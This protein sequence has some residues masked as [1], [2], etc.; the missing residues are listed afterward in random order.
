MR[1]LL[2][3]KPFLPSGVAAVAQ[4]AT[5][6]TAARVVV[7]VRFPLLIETVTFAVED[8][9]VFPDASWIVATG[10]VVKFARFTKPATPVVTTTL[11]AA[12]ALTAIVCAASVMPNIE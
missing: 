10:C 7:P 9:T 3:T 2:P 11:V 12:P 6:F 1:V 5:P 4:F 8:V